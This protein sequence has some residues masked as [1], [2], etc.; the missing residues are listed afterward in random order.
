MIHSADFC[1]KSRKFWFLMEYMIRC[2]SEGTDQKSRFK[3]KWSKIS[4]NRF[5]SDCQVQL[6]RIS[7]HQ[8]FYRSDGAQ[9]RQNITVLLSTSGRS[10][11]IS[12]IKTFSW[13]Q[14][15]SLSGPTARNLKLIVWSKMP[16]NKYFVTIMFNPLLHDLL[17]TLIM[18]QILAMPCKTALYF[19][20][21]WIK[22]RLF[23]RSLCTTRKLH[24]WVHNLCS[25]K[26]PLLFGRIQIWT[27]FIFFNSL[28]FLIS[29]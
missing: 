22:G 9:L 10:M 1:Q 3:V 20:I 15:L 11:S 16:K 18:S 5:Y 29:S 28:E 21:I 27:I 2:L 8:D 24:G 4:W 25:I 14:I 13:L 17:W 26:E 19:Q 12:L 6:I 23:K 7:C